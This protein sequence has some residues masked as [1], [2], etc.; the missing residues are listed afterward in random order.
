MVTATKRKIFRNRCRRCRIIFSCSI[1]FHHVLFIQ[2]DKSI[3]DGRKGYFLPN[4]FKLHGEN[5]PLQ[6]VKLETRLSVDSLLDGSLSA[7]QFGS[8]SVL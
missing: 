4:D 7:S 8:G 5:K 3:A 6:L 2:I 1:I